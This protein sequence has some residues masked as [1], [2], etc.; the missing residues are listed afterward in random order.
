[1]KQKYPLQEN[2]STTFLKYF[3]EPNFKKVVPLFLPLL[4][5]MPSTDIRTL[6]DLNSKSEF[7]IGSEGE[8]FTKASGYQTTL[9]WM[10][11]TMLA[12]EDDVRFHL[13]YKNINI[14]KCPN[15]KYVYN[16]TN[17][18]EEQF[19]KSFVLEGKSLNY[20]TNKTFNELDT[21]ALE[22]GVS[23]E[24][25]NYDYKDKIS[26]TI[27]NIFNSMFSKISNIKFIKSENIENANVILYNSNHA[28]AERV[29][30]END[31]I[32]KTIL[33]IKIASLI[34]LD[35]NDGRFNDLVHGLAH[36]FL[37]HPCENGFYFC[38]KETT[39]NSSDK[40]FAL[41]ALSG[42]GT[43]TVEEALTSVAKSAL[44][45]LDA[46]GEQYNIQS[47]LPLDI[48]ALRYS[49]GMPKPIAIT[50]QLNNN[51]ALKENFGW[52]IINHSLVCFSSTGNVTI[53]ARNVEHYSLNLNYEEFSNIT[54]S[55]ID[56]KFLLSYDTQIAKILINNAGP[57]ALNNAFSTDIVIDPG[58]YDVIIHGD[59]YQNDI[60]LNS[61]NNFSVTDKISIIDIYNFNDSI[62]QIIFL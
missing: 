62:H 16:D 42:I 37:D 23:S 10:K 55:A 28:S 46:S 25:L 33:G 53:D 58:F 2:G 27:E 20:L 38:N 56:Y 43:Y 11:A 47:L 34:D 21:Q 45:K 8:F 4:K 54:N 31:V 60:I 13:F 52:P 30:F 57:I 61:Y 14:A 35:N 39:Q 19:F 12:E 15:L 51:E 3:I 24:S 32:T 41:T 50:Y 26:Q 5:E 17:L 59:F 22:D 49:Y 44:K 9:D 29:F 48:A 40:F 6:C 1:M 36:L 7:K 18:D